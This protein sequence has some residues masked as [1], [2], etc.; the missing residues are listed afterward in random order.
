M[1]S[2]VAG[3]DDP[4][5]HLYL[6]VLPEVHKKSEV[7]GAASGTQLPCVVLLIVHCKQELC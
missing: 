4:G 6:R 7:L 5:S 2:I 1:H 3:N